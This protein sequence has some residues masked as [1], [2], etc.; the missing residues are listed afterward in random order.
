MQGTTPEE[1]PEK[2]KSDV[3]PMQNGSATDGK[4][5]GSRERQAGPR[6]IDTFLNRRSRV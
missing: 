1:R 3:F 2:T 4:A 6:F 5:Q